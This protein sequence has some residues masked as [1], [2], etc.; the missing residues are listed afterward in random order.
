MATSRMIGRVSPSSSNPG[1]SSPIKVLITKPPRLGEIVVFGSLYTVYKDPRNKNFTLTAQESMLIGVGEEIEG[2]C[3]YL[4]KDK[5]VTMAQNVTTIETLDKTQ[6][7]Q[8]QCLYSREDSAESEE[9]HFSVDAMSGVPQ[10]GPRACE[11]RI[12]GHAYTKTDKEVELKLIPH[13]MIV[14]EDIT[15]ALNIT[16]VNELALEL[17]KAL[18]GLKQA[19]RRCK[20]PLHQELVEIGLVQSLAE[21]CVYF[22][23]WDGDLLVLGVYVNGILGSGVG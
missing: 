6:S 19:G 8:V 23:S 3:V 12:C 16:S 11:A 18:Y 1:S 5:V 13:G 20:K 15:K 10:K 17:H 21:L 22:R 4:P 14:T 9:E 2:Y 7:E